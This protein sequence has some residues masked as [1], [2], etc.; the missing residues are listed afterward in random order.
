MTKGKIPL[1]MNGRIKMMDN[2]EDV[3]LLFLKTTEKFM[4]SKQ[5]GKELG[6]AYST[7]HH[8]L[9]AM[10]EQGLLEKKIDKTPRPGRKSYLFKFKE[11]EQKE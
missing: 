10:T 8:R 11:Q 1:I 3:L 6:L 4:T 7:I 2:L 9:V 5:I